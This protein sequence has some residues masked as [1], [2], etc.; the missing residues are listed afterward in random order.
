MLNGLLNL[1]FG[2]ADRKAKKEQQKLDNQYRNEVFQYQKDIQQQI[3]ER[4]DNAVQRRVKD[5]ESAGMNKLL[6]GGEGAQASGLGMSTT[7]GGEAPTTNL[8]DMSITGQVLSAIDTKNR[9][10]NS[11]VERQLT[12]AKTLE[13]LSN[14]GR[15]NQWGE[16]S[17]S[18]VKKNDQWIEESKSNQRYNNARADSEEWNKEVYSA[19][20]LPTNFQVNSKYSA[21]Q[22]A[23]FMAGNIANSAIKAQNERAK[24]D[25][26]VD[27][28][29]GNEKE[30]EKENRLKGF[31][32][33]QN[34]AVW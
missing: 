8:G 1:G 22:A 17:K 16:E 10:Q 9:L 13:A 24:Q 21:G 18:N 7:A 33:E 23:I 15:N 4:E 30:K 12:Q 5:L 32:G 27:I 25:K 20:G 29:Y 31:F 34:G 26:A 19:Y 3:F 2:I 11:E 28:I 14:V 6:A